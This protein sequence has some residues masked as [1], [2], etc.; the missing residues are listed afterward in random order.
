MSANDVLAAVPD[1]ERDRL[2][3]CRM[4]EWVE[5]M[6]A[7]LTHER[8]SK[9]GWIFERKFDGERCLAFRDGGRPRL[10]S[11]NRKS[12]NAHYPEVV[13]ALAAQDLTR[14]VVDGEVVAFSGGVSSFSRLQARMHVDDPEAARNTGVAVTYYVFDV[15]HLGDY[16]VS[17]LPQRRRKALL[18]RF[19]SFADP[20][21][22][23]PHRNAEG[24]AYFED[25]CRKGWEG[26]I[27][28][29]AGA[30]YAHTRS[31]HWLK[32]KCVAQQ[33]LVVGGFTDPH[34]Q[35]S[36]FG[37]LLLGYYE[38][39]DLRYA[40]KVG[41]GFDE[42]TLDRLGRRLR[43]LESDQSPFE[44]D[45]DLPEREVH[46]VKPELVAEIGFEEWTKTDRLRQPRFL[47]LR[48]DKAAE[49][50]VREDPG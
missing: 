22:F 6:L 37:A 32:F 46:W 8:F 42:D 26:I 14:F 41:T 30:A 40:G 20:L 45:D 9:D 36:G 44:R 25:A 3:R 28:K 35:R 18:K 16:K 47:G 12:L 50:V 49:D 5:P 4:P 2:E 17:R 15:L 29:D 21:R 27:A 7:T 11:R 13:E 48:E 10:M 24:E 1:S 38:G 34:G 33:E 31:R 43:S 23:T 19:L 39:R